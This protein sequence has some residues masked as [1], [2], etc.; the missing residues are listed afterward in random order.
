MVQE[1]EGGLPKIDKQCASLLQRVNKHLTHLAAL[2]DDSFK[3]DAHQFRT[4][5][6]LL[7]DDFAEFVKTF[8]RNRKEVFTITEHIIDGE[9]MVRQ[10]NLVSR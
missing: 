8:R 2:I 9:K 10:L 1:I 5:H 4:E 7:E 6:E 3:Y